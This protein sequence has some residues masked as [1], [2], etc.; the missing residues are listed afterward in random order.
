MATSPNGWL[1]VIPQRPVHDVRATQEYY[2]DVLGFEIDWLWE[3]SYGSVHNEQGRIYFTRYE[4]PFE[5]V[6]CCANVPD[7][8]AVYAE[9]KGRGAEIVAELETKPW[10]MREFTLRDPNGHCFRV[11]TGV[12]RVDDI[13]EFTTD[14][15]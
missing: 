10:G 8:D 5:G 7:V 11:G 4:E 13:P 3:D 9:Y 12:K 6:I 2:R 15:A 1:I 14:F